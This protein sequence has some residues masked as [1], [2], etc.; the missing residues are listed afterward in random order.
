MQ[1][2]L[3]SV[4]VVCPALPGSKIKFYLKPLPSTSPPVH[5]EQRV[6]INSR[7]H[8]PVLVFVLTPLVLQLP[9]SSLDLRNEHEVQLQTT[10]RKLQRLKELLK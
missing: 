6:W 7:A 10:E 8:K 1:L 5:A 3:L 4:C 9:K 2:P